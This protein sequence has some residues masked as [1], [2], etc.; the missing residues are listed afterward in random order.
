MILFWCLLVFFGVMARRRPAGSGY[1][2]IFAYLD[3]VVPAVTKW[4]ATILLVVW[5]LTLG[6]ATADAMPY[7]NG[8]LGYALDICLTT[9]LVLFL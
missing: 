7:F 5:L 9:L 1:A 8:S 3:S 6:I 2:A 4:F